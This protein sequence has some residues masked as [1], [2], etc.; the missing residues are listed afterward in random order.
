[1]LKVI[2]DTN[3][4]IS[5]LLSK[6]IPSKILT[7]LILTSKV[8]IFLSQEILSEY[9][10]I[11]LRPKFHSIPDFPINAQIVINRLEELSISIDPLIK[12]RE[13][14]DEKD[15]RFLELAASSNAD[16]LITGNTNDFTMKEFRSTKIITPTN[17]WNYCIENGIY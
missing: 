7:E 11:A 12:L 2:L 9:S 13:I 1:M 5:A 16:F 10:E 4:L 14:K 15:N 6:G 17:F 3:V 8:E